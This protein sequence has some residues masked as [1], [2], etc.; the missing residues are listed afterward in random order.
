MKRLAS[1]WLSFLFWFTLLPGTR[2]LNAAE[3][4]PDT[5]AGNLAAADGVLIIGHRGCAMH[6]PENTLVSFQAAIRAGADVVNNFQTLALVRRF[7]DEEVEPQTV[8]LKSINFAGD[9]GL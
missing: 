2:S 9:E 1:I 8:L 7:D 4:F 5:P 3:K 6:A